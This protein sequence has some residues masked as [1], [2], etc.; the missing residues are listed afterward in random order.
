[1]RFLDED[2]ELNPIVSAVNLV[3]VFLVIIAA[4]MIALAQPVLSKYILAY[5]LL[6]KL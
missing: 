4:L 3:D 2:E 1:M 6:K 5:L